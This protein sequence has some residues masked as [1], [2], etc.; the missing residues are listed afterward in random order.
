M[1]AIL[2]FFKKMQEIFIRATNLHL[3]SEKH[4]NHVSY[5][6]TETELTNSNVILSRCLA[7]TNIVHLKARIEECRV[8]LAELIRRIELLE[9]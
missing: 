9:N 6:K 1:S 4:V 2:W 5:K 7:E 8:E 3:N